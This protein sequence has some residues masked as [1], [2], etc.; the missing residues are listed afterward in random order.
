MTASIKEIRR[1][2]QASRETEFYQFGWFEGNFIRK[3]SPYF[4]KLFLK[5]RI[6]ANQVTFISLLVGIAAGIFLTFSS[7]RFWI[8]GA[9]LLYLF[10]ILDDVDG[11]VAR[12]NKTASPRG[13]FW[14]TI[15]GLFVWQFTLA[16]ASFGIYSALNEIAVLVFGFSAIV[17]LF[18]YN[19]STLL[20]YPI[21]HEKG[22]LLKALAD[23]PEKS[24]KGV[25]RYGQAV[26]GQGAQGLFHGILVT[27]LID[28]FLSPFAIAGFSFNFRFIYLI[29][30]DVALLLGVMIKIYNVHRRG[31]KVARF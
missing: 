10:L 4:T 24:F 15:S 16:C 11:E 20:S 30:Y 7:T 26:F 19:I 28:C 31:V 3:V 5:I 23:R 22:L 21:L 18:L 29:A 8:I 9:L 2:C 17:L 13:A 12:Y 14:D 27:S 25:L 1:I 6:S